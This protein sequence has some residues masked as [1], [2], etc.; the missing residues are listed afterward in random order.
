MHI[1]R[2]NVDAG[3]TGDNSGVAAAR[4]GTTQG[5]WTPEEGKLERAVCALL[6]HGFRVAAPEVYVAF[7]P[8][9]RGVHRG[10]F[11]MQRILR[12]DEC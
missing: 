11:Q 3:T 9:E 10:R 12:Y 4:T 2:T 6:S 1:Y 8:L 7:G 5:D